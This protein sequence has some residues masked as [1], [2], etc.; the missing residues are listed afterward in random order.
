MVFMVVVL[1]S[2]IPL[3]LSSAFAD[4]G[5]QVPGTVEEAL[6]SPQAEFW[7]EA[8]DSEMASLYQNGT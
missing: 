8:M 7:K 6:A 3:V 4:D 5:V 1:S 2:L